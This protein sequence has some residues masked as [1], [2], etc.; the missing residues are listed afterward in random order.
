MTSIYKAFS[1]NN[2]LATLFL[3]IK[4]A[5]DGV[6]PRLLAQALR[7]LGQPENVFKFFYNLTSSH[8]V[9]FNINGVVKGPFTSHKGLPQ[10]CSLS[11]TLY[12]ISS[13]SVESQ[14]TPDCNCLNFADDIV[15][16]CASN[17][18]D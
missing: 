3:D 4:G 7:N 14:L 13:K 8:S 10:G 17:K 9:Y 15:L 6:D 1:N 12:N 11:P 2:F 18:I 16:Y 5:F